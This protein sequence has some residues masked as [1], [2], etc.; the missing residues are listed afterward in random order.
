MQEVS[1]ALSQLRDL[2]TQVLGQPA[3]EIQSGSYAPFPLGVD[4]LQ[5]AVREVHHLQQ[6]S[7]QAAQR[8]GPLTWVPRADSFATDDTYLIRIEIPGVERESLKVL[9]T[10]GECVVR[11]ERK[12]PTGSP[13]LRP[14]NL[15]REWGPFE[16]RF[17]LPPGF[18]AEKVSAHYSEGLL[19]L[20]VEVPKQ[21]IIKEMKVEVV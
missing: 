19:E 13:G 15:E 17:V 4:P 3:P 14:M 5:H 11:G 12:L 10:N 2:Y 6:L 9:V 20:K 18:N 16:R 7:Q 1:Q 8:P 21:G